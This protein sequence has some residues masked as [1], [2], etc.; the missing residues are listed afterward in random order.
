MSAQ[1]LGLQA[2]K[3]LPTIIS[4]KVELA[5]VKILL[6]QPQIGSLDVLKDAGHSWPTD[7][8]HNEDDPS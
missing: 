7:E 2:T 3:T 6:N 5:E 8:Y 1:Q 4:R